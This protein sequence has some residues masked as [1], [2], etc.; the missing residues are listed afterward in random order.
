MEQIQITSLP[1]RLGQFLKLAEIVQDGIDAKHLVQSGQ[2]FLNNKVETRRG[3]QLEAKDVV[4]VF[5]K[6][7]QVIPEINRKI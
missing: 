7:Y 6:E 4:T 1:I 3:K 2:V 5:G